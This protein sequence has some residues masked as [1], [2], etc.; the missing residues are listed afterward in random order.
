MRTQMIITAAVGFTRTTSFQLFA[1]Y[2]SL[3]RSMSWWNRSTCS[4]LALSVTE[5][6]M[7]KPSPVLM[8]CSLIALNSSW[9]AVSSTGWMWKQKHITAHSLITQSLW[10]KVC[11]II[12]LFTGV[13]AQLWPHTRYKRVEVVSIFLNVVIFMLHASFYHQDSPSSIAHCPS[14]SVCFRYESSIVGS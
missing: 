14:I 5:K 2:L 6:T 3:T 11:C 10:S 8:Y 12:H 7:R 4:K 13:F 1:S 9:P